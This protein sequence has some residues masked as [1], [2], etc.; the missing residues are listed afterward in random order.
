MLTI[1]I[2]AWAFWL[3]AGMA[4]VSAALR[5]V[6]IYYTRELRKLEDERVSHVQ[7]LHAGPHT[8]EEG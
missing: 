7:P 4:V 6:E 2:P 8:P 1:T 3:L 5:L